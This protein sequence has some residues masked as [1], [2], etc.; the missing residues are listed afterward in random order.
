ME[1]KAQ[2]LWETFKGELTQPATEDQRQALATAIREIATLVVMS[3]YQY[4]EWELADKICD[5]ILNIADELDEM[6]TLETDH[7]TLE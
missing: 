4:A 2:E 7:S 5:E 3:Y 1:T 6:D